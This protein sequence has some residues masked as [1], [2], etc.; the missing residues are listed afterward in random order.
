MEIIDM[1]I[2]KIDAE[3]CTGCGQCIEACGVDVIRM[4]NE[5]QKALIKYPEDCMVCGYCDL[6][7]PEEAITFTPDK[8]APL[9]VAWR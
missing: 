6:D 2:E 7:C 3:K 5:A 1:A 9:L 8:H 4:D